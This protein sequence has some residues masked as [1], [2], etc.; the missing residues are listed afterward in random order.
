MPLI[1]ANQWQLMYQ[2]LLAKY[3]SLE[4]ENEALW[5]ELLELRDN[6]LTEELV[7]FLDHNLEETAQESLLPVSPISLM[8]H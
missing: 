7:Q 5:E 6:L 2:A 1:P 3:Q 8:R 4:A